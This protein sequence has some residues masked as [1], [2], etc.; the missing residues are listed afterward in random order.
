MNDRCLGVL[1]MLDSTI[2]KSDADAD[3]AP[4]SG[5]GRHTTYV[6]IGHIGQ[7]TTK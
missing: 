5:V 4:T 3:A 1:L 2:L 7:S 6:V